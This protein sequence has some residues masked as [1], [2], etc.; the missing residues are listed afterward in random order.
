MSATRKKL[1]GAQNRKRASHRIDEEA[2][3]AAKM[4]RWLR[5]SA[6]SLAPSDS[7]IQNA[8]T[9]TERSDDGEESLSPVLCQEQDDD[10]QLAT[11]DLPQSA[12]QQEGEIID[13]MDPGAWPDTEK[14]TDMQR[15]FL[16]NQAVLLND[17]HPN[18]IEF[19]F[20]E[21]NG[22]RLTYSMWFRTMT[23]KENIKR[24]WLVY[25]KTK[26]SIYCFACKLYSN[27][28]TPLS[29]LRS[30]GFINWK[31]ASERLAEHEASQAHKE[32]VIKWKT[33][34]QQIKSCQGIDRDVELL[35]Q[36]EKEKWR[37]ILHVVMDAVMYLATNCLSFRGSKETIND[38]TINYP[39]PN[40]GNFLNLIIL[41][42]KHNPTLKLHLDHLQKGQVS[43]L[44]KTVQN[45]IIQLLA[46]NVRNT[47]IDEIKGANYFTIMFDCTPDI[48]HNE[49]MSQVFQYVKITGSECEI[50]ESFIDFVQV[51][52]KT[53][54]Y[55][56]Q[57]I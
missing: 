15:S 3:S 31:K 11:S 17:K 16:S 40:Q 14:M 48:A 24:T 57:Q 38:L 54:E 37:Q 51:G 22:R 20:T 42:A 45:E 26:N 44:S 53:G 9:A 52:G 28:F 7:D 27:V 50:K 35:I 19:K 13:L 21:R 47:I 6:A 2:Q 18:N 43:Y 5:E 34:L 4:R 56:T 39:Q 46:C 8:T 23:N 12:S 33:R 55:I 30:V 29:A 49:Q 25:S 1:S 41:L 32:C 10:T 36:S